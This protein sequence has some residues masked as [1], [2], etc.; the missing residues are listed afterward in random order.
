MLETIFNAANWFA[1]PFWALMILLPGWKVTRRVMESLLPIALLATV[2]LYLL[3]TG[4]NADTL[5]EFSNPQLSLNSLTSLFSQPSVMATGWVHYIVM[6]LFVGRW[7]FLEGW[8]KRVWTTHSLLLCLFA[9]PVG[10]LSH[11][12]TVTVVQGIRKG[13]PGVVGA[14]QS[15]EVPQESS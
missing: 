8:E 9:G 11:L 5:Q 12:L 6:D 7:I 1:L 14:D 15:A 10:L 2:Y 13:R 3:V 4:F